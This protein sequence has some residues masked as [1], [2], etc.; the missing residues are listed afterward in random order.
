[1]D[2]DRIA[3][4]GAA[5]GLGVAVLN[6]LR[7]RD[8]EVVGL[9]RSAADARMLDDYGAKAVLGDLRE[10]DSVR[11]AVRGADVV[12]HLA[13]WMGSPGGFEVAREVNVEG[14][15]HVIR[16]A[17][18]EGVRRVVIASSI[19]VH[20]PVADGEI[21]EDEPLRKIGDPYGDTKLEAEQ[22]ARDVADELGLELVVL[23][24]TMI[25]GPRSGSWTV[26]PLQAIRRG[27]PAVI[28]SGDDL[29]DAVYVGDVARAF[30]LAAETPA[31]AGETFII[32]GETTD[33]NTFF[34][35]YADM[36]DQPVRR[37]PEGLIKGGARIAATATSWLTGRQRVVPETIDVM[38]SRASY[39]HAKARDILGYVPQVDLGEGMRRTAAWLRASGELRRPATALVTGAASGLGSAV[40]RE[41]H[42]AG[43]H[44]YATDV[45]EDAL[46]PLTGEGVTVLALDV[47]DPASIEAARS[48]IEAEGRTVDVVV[49]AAGLARPG[50]LVNQDLSDVELQFDVNAYGPLHVA[51]AFAPAMIERGWG[52]IVNVSSTNGFIVSPFMGAYSAA[53]HAVEALSDALRL[54]LGPFG[55]EV[56]VVEPG[57]MRTPFAARAKAALHQEIESETSAW[58]TYLERFMNSSLWG[59]EG[60]T[61]PARVARTIARI[62]RKGG[63]ARVH[64]T[65]DAFPVRF[66]SMMPVGV[67]DLFFRN[68]AGLKPLG[69]EAD[70]T[71]ETEADEPHREKAGPSNE[72]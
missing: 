40:V 52:R 48:R 27:L 67:K 19:A 25:Y 61:D 20:G 34:G 66:M 31:A 51:R 29:L 41:L 46:E 57:A 16:A 62:A 13:A 55:V 6:E 72:G 8:V 21:T 28:G 9:V 71:S 64:A 36:Y 38:T 33:W 14:T 42:D 45:R 69:G 30:V 63:R 18:R 70:G 11:D 26:T 22:R 50:V 4:T 10:P 68:A 12:L 58:S 3:V 60:G 56:V 1:M 2:I 65:L 39:S 7:S 43:I 44:V 47:T 53:K 32:G 59:D 37:L 5:G 49:N 54:E 24:P 35:A 15:E 23:R 17:A